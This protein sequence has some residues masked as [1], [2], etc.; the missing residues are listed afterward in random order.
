MRVC[1]F[2]SYDPQYPRN[3]IV[4]EGLALNEVEVLECNVPFSQKRRLADRYQQLLS[5]WKTIR[6]KKPDVLIL[7]E[8]NHKNWPL[9]ACIA[10]KAGI[11]LVFDPLVSVYNTNIE[12][13]QRVKKQSLGALRDFMLDI[14]GFRFSDAILADTQTHR[15]Y[16]CRKWGAQPGRVHVS[17]VG[18]DETYFYPTEVDKDSEP[19]TV[20][21]FGSYIPLHGT[22]TIIKAF[23]QLRQ[24]QKLNARLV[25]IGNGQ[26]LAEAKQLA[27]S[28]NIC[29]LEFIPRLPMELLASTVRNA[30]ICLGIFGETEKAQ[31]VI[32][33]KVFQ[34]LCAGKPVITCDSPAMREIFVDREHLIMVPCGDDRKLAQ[35]IAETIA[36]SDLANSLGSQGS[37]LVHRYFTRIHIGKQVLEILNRVLAH[38]E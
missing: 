36:E 37:K 8:F 31:R 30:S 2:G 21:F 19:P 26:T 9:A 12:D 20:L 15:S 5:K 32:P 7:P 23:D 38:A 11:P 25:M 10:R 18:A 1:Y 17:Y 33:H 28:L 27:R 14:V 35:A 6:T 24:S 16:F 22:N 13:R 3:K 34:A 29:D 4:R